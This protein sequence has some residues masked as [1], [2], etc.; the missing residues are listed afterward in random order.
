MMLISCLLLIIF[1]VACCGD[2]EKLISL[3]NANFQDDNVITDSYK[4][5][6]TLLGLH[7]KDHKILDIGEEGLSRQD[8]VNVRKLYHSI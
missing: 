8:I 5:L 1:N 7:K 4:V 2:V 3:Y 6:D